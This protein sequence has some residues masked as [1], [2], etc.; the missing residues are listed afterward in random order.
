MNKIKQ[1]SYNKSRLATILL[2]FFLGN[3]GLANFYTGRTLKGIIQL[4][5]S[6]VFSW[7][8][9]IPF[10]VWLWAFIESCTYKTDVNGRTLT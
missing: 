4:A 1:Q 2:G 8:G 6:I 10:L 5:L 3:F 7:T 9:V